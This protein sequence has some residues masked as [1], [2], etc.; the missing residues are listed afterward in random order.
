MAVG[1]TLDHRLLVTG[2][3]FVIFF[4]VNSK[5]TTVFA[6]SS[7]LISVLNTLLGF[8]VIS[9]S[10][11]LSMALPLEFRR[12]FDREKNKNVHCKCD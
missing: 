12:C 2:V 1:S 10:Y 6:Q 9:D 8:H 11:D 3:T 7:H 4:G 5:I